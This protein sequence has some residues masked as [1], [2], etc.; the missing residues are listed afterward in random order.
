M[1]AVASTGPRLTFVVESG[2]DVRLVDGLAERF[3][4]S[5]LCRRI[6][7]GVEVS[8]PPQRSVRVEIGP[9]SRL[10]FALWIAYRLVRD[11]DS[12]D[13]V[14]VQGY[15]LAALV[16]N[17]LSR[18]TRKLTAM[19]I[20][21]PI[22]IYYRC[23]ASGKSQG[24]AYHAFIALGLATLARLNARF[25]KR[26]FVLSRHLAEVVRGHGTSAPIEI[27]PVY[28]VDTDVFSPSPEP[29][30]HLRA[31]L[32]LPLESPLLLF[33]SR[34]APEKDVDTLLKAIRL[35]REKGRVLWVINRSGGHDEFS[36]RA[37]E[38]GVGPA[39]VARDALH[40]VK[41]LPDLY[42]AVDL[43][44]QASR[45]EGL[46]FSVL[47]ALACGTAVVAAAV[48]G[49]LET[50]IEGETGWTYPN[51]DV[52]ALVAAIEAALD[53]PEEARRRAMAGREMVV[54]RFEREM[55]FR[56]LENRI[57]A[58]LRSSLNEQPVA[59]A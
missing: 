47:E 37:T 14:L 45:A 49:L 15:G 34:V 20:C 39:V 44:V 54:S 6:V 10:S 4:V 13:L 12:V 16:A 17:L 23:R 42:R 26:Y 35:L 46:G 25:G 48:G 41:E 57:H 33:S 9:S 19:L 51:G 36:R 21:S 29:R 28:G 43:C 53:H 24:H 59:S 55:V 32:G 56:T 40:P 5:L 58:A 18:S 30:S 11:R 52:E 2:T 3:E 31:K 8:W 27:I 1:A 7:G 22:E 50:V 38:L